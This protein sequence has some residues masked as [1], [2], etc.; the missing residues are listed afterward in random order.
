MRHEDCPYEK[1]DRIT[2]HKVLKDIHTDSQ[3][4]LIG[5][6]FKILE[7]HPRIAH[8]RLQP[9]AAR[10]AENL[11]SRRGLE[12]TGIDTS[13]NITRRCAEKIN[14]TSLEINYLFT[15]L[16]FA[17]GKGTAIGKFVDCGF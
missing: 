10:T 8:I 4:T 3:E 1:R 16:P 11:H 7:K 5:W 17:L 9:E 13:P 12:F 2:G 15:R 14:T 6:I